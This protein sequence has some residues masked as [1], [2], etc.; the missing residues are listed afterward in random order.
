MAIALM[1]AL[2]FCL[3]W[4]IGPQAALAQERFEIFALLDAG[5]ALLILPGA[6]LGAA[7]GDT[8]GAVFGL[9]AAT[10][11]SGNRD[12]RLALTQLRSSRRPQPARRDRC[13]ARLRPARLELGSADAAQPPG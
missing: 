7:I 5:P 2:P 6:V 10:I 8:E 11:G 3:L 13:R 1:V 9:A 4:R 12:D